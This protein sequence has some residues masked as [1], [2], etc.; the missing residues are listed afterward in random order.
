MASLN[1]WN[2]LF[3]SLP[4]DEADARISVGLK[5]KPEAIDWFVIA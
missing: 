4:G 3:G 1:R 5:A 2:P